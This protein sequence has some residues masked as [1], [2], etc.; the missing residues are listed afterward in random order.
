MS[1]TGGGH[2]SAAD[3][4]RSAFEAQRAMPVSVEILDLLRTELPKP[5]GWL[6]GA[7]QPLVHHAPW[8]WRALW[9][10]TREPRAVTLL[11]TA[12]TRLMH[13]SIAALMERQRPDLLVSVHPLL[14]HI[15]LRSLVIHG[16]SI[17]YF[18]VVTDWANPH[19]AWFHPAATQVFVGTD[20]AAEMAAT[21]QLQRQRVRLLGL[22]VRPAFYH[23]VGSKRRQ[24]TAL[25]MDGSLPMALLTGGAD[26][27]GPICEIAR[28]LDARLVDGAGQARGQ[29]CV[30]CGHNQG[31]QRR[32][33]RMSWRIPIRIYGFSTRLAELMRAA[34]CIITKAGPGTISEALVSGLPLILFGCIPGQEE[35]N[36][37][38]VTTLGAGVYRPAPQQ[39]AAQ[40]AHWFGDGADELAGCAAHARAASRPDASR[41][42]AADILERVSL[43]EGEI[44]GDR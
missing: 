20:A 30:V 44:A 42:I 39:V 15:V 16:L 21:Q 4:L 36:S 14:Q 3:A 22:P 26:G 12:A 18:T 33:Q 23:A 17:P 28:Q 6:P 41:S 40:V 37:S 24:R 9:I 5:L 27:V 31:L 19:P 38:L 35:G 25:G 13:R 34:D 2:R 43:R 10:A 1:D 7:Y 32:L 11:T 29:L 8:L